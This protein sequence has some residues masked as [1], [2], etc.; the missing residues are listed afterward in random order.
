MRVGLFS[1]TFPPELNGVANS[2][3]ILRDELLRHG[4][5]VYVITTRAGTGKAEWDADGKV[6]RLAGVKLKFLYGYVMTS[7]LHYYAFNE[8]KKLHLDVIH[9]QTEFGVGIFA[10]ICSNNLHI[11]LVSTYHTTYEDYT[12]YVNFMNSNTVDMVAKK[13]VAHLSKLY[14]DSSLEVIAP[15]RKTKDMLMGYKVRSQINVI[16]TG[17]ELFKFK[18]ESDDASMRMKIRSEYGFRD[19]DTVIIFVGR[20]AE[21]KALD[22]VINGFD[23]VRKDGMDVKF[24]VIGSGPQ[25]DM[26]KKQAE[27]LGLEGTVVFA[28][29]KESDIV[30]EYYRACDAFVSASLTETQGMTFIEALASGLPVFARKD[31]VLEDLVDEGST[32]YY[33]SDPH[34]FS[35]AVR[36]FLSLNAQQRAEQKEACIAKTKAYSSETFYESVIQVYENAIEKYRHMYTIDDVKVKDDYVQLYVTAMNPQ[37]ELRILV[38]LDDYYSKGLSRGGLL[39]ADQIHTLQNDEA[40]VRA[41]QGC[42]R[43]LAL[44]DR[45][46]KEMYDWLTQN[47]EC[48]IQAINA[49]IER[50]EEKGYIN[51]ERYCEESIASM[52]RGL[53]GEDKIIRALKKKG[54]PYELIRS[55]LDESTNDESANA[56][57]Y[58]KK[59]AASI[60]DESV[61]SKKNS[62]VRKLIQ[63][64]FSSDIAHETANELDFSKDEMQ[65]MDNLRHCAQKA[66]KRYEKKYQGSRLRNT[67]YRYCAAKG[68]SNEDIYAILDEMEW[69]DDKD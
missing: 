20:I 22:I 38:S 58:A 46:R 16:P 67:I 5:D 54:L 23:Q 12:H 2:T 14:G 7:P 4:H 25:E 45:T 37:D 52:Q 65:E 41:Y 6:L 32:G 51:D 66:R 53:Q 44:R 64:G 33:F 34:D 29:R 9:A 56:L 47:T 28:G 36:T 50:L 49:I 60:K 11:P 43:K 3:A 26:Y 39:S 31:E 24:L 59:A 13:A 40:G 61:R 15:S 10:H 69:E 1:D 57:E 68:Y 8:V 17:L 21:E 48:S 27:D 42:M 63:R 18:P 55:K 30:P 35:D 19:T 62:V